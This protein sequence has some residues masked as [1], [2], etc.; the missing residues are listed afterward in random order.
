VFGPPAGKKYAIH[1]DDMNMPLREDYGAQPPI[2][3][4]RQWFDQSGWYDRKELTFRNIVDITFVGSMGPP[5][6]GGKLSRRVFC[7][8]LTRSGT[9][10]CRTSPRRPSLAPS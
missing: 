4:L 3:I 2:E 10:K 1:V 7:G 8:T 5:G 6:G 9:W